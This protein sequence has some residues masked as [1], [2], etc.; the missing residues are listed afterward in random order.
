MAEKIALLKKSDFGFL[1]IF[2]LDLDKVWPVQI[3]KT[4][5]GLKYLVCQ[6]FFPLI[7]GQFSR[8]CT[9]W[10]LNHYRDQLNS[11]LLNI[12]QLGTRWL[13]YVSGDLNNQLVLYSDA[14]YYDKY[15]IPTSWIQFQIPTVNPRSVPAQI[16]RNFKF[17][18][19]YF[20]PRFIE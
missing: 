2:E 20:L 11:H 19:F 3:L 8:Y 17:G 5:S 18:S 12:Y 1:K 9:M 13:L 16:K 14:W 6:D 10:N 15:K 4:T 7:N